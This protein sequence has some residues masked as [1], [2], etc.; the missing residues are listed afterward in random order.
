MTVD[1]V[2]PPE[3]CHLSD[4]VKEKTF[5]FPVFHDFSGTITCENCRRQWQFQWLEYTEPGTWQ[6]VWRELPRKNA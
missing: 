2:M 5:A 3:K 1:V 4:P 6:A